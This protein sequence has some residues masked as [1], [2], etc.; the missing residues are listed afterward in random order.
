M[1][2]QKMAKQNFLHNLF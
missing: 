2:D 1:K